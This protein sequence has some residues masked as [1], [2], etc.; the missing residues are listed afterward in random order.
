MKR[1]TRCGLSAAAAMAL[2]TTAN[3]LAEEQESDASV[4]EA[5]TVSA[6][7][8]TENVQNISV[9]VDA[10]SGDQLEN[11]GISNA[12]DISNIS[13]GV[14]I[15]NMT[16]DSTPTISIRGESSTPSVRNSA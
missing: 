2:L 13:P 5:I 7:K 14:V 8:R 12:A 16:G 15:S 10:F 3:S 1:S 11:M 6:Q 9:V 4:Y